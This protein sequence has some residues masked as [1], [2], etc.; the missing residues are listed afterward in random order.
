MDDSEFGVLEE[1][2]RVLSLDNKF[3]FKH[4]F[5][6]VENMG[7]PYL[8]QV[9]KWRKN[10]APEGLMQICVGTYM[11]QVIWNEMGLRTASAYSVNL[12]THP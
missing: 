12:P 5:L 7:K 1:A 8:K 9:V 3:I 2:H 6:K 4:F 11:G 10:E